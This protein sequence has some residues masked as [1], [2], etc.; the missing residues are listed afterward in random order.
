[1]FALD[2]E[3]AA[4]SGAD[5]LAGLKRIIPRERIKQVLART[6]KDRAFCPRLPAFFMVWFVLGL[7]L[8]CR[9]CYRQVFRWLVRWGGRGSVPGRSTLC[10]ARQRLGVAP[11]VQLAQRTVR[12][13]ANPQTPGAFYRGRRLMALDGFVVD[14]PDSPENQRVFGKPA[15]GRAPGAFP[16]ARVV[17]LCE[18]G[19]H[20]LYRWGI[21][22][23][24]VGESTMA[25]RLLDFLSSHMLLLWDRNF[26]SYDRVQQVIGRGATLLARVKNHLVFRPIRCLGDGSYLA[27]LYRNGYDRQHDRAGL[28]VR[29]IEYTFDD[30]HRPGQGQKHRLLTL[31]LDETLDPAKTL[32]ELYHLRWEEELSI[33]EAKTHQLER[34]CLRSQTPAGVAQEL[35]ALLIDHFVIRVLMFEAAA[36]KPISPLR[37]S[38]T[39]TLKILRCRIPHCPRRLRQRRRWW[40]RLLEEIA[41]EVIEPRRNRVNPRVIKRKMSKW[42]KK[43]PEHRHN[44]QPTK[45]FRAAIVM[46]R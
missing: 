32:I 27:K 36:T 7:G 41:E 44:P 1:M 9:D 25:R 34:P 16:Q 39:A 28:L 12:L 15:G 5:R 24:R 38:F 13:L 21:K 40:R 35:Y 18:A 26:L 45:N 30:P 14:L 42:K 23:I 22:P 2:K 31:L 4:L 43:R 29:I 20:V 8:F 10:E 19:T 6:G 3:V 17:A 11:L 46:L 37:L 33:D